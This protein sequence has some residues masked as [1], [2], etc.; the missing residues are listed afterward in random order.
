MMPPVTVKTAELS[1]VW[2]SY[3]KR[4]T[5][6]QKQLV[7]DYTKSHPASIV[8]AFL[9][10]NNFT[11]NTRMGQLDSLYQQLDTSVRATYFENRFKIRSEK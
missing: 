4:W 11:Y 2:R 3:M 9:V 8:A 7:I 6:K 10:Y 1:T 5:L